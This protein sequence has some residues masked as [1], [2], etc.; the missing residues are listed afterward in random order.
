MSRYVEMKGPMHEGLVDDDSWAEDLSA[1]LSQEYPY[2]VNHVKISSDE[3]YWT[4][5]LIHKP[6]R[7]LSDVIKSNIRGHVQGWFHGA[8]GES[9]R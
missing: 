5:T 9:G 4:V 3:S 1:S 2:C 8:I 7:N 6:K